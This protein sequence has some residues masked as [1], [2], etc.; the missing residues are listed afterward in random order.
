MNRKNQTTGTR[1][2]LME[3]ALGNRAPGLFIQN[4]DIFNT[5]T[6]TVDREM[7]LLVWKDRIAHVGP[8]AELGDAG[9]DAATIVVDAGGR[10]LIPGFIDSH[11]HLA[12]LVKP[13]EYVRHVLP[14]GCTT[15]ITETME[16]YPVAGVNGVKAYLEALKKQPMRF[17]TT[18]PAMAS[19]SSASLGLPEGDAEV[20]AALDGM[21]GVGEAYWQTVFQE[22]AHFLGLFEKTL[23]AGG[24][25]E[26]HSAGARGRKLSAYAALGVSSCH[27]PISADQVLE[28]LAM[29]FHVQI[30]EGSIRSDL[31][32]IAAIAGAGVDLS[33]ISLVSDGITPGDLLANGYMN[34]IVQK[35]VDNGFRPEDAIRMA[36]LN[37]ARHFRLDHEI[38]SLAPGRFADMVLIPD[39]ETIEPEMVIAKGAV[40]AENK[41]LRVTPVSHE[42]DAPCL[43]TVHLPADISEDDLAVASPGSGDTARVRTI[44]FIT[45]LVTREC[46]CDLP[47]SDG[48]VQADIGQDVIKAMAVDRACAPGLRTGRRFTGFVKGFGLKSGAL[49]TSAAWDGSE[50]I[51]LGKDDRDIALAVN[52]IRREK[53]GIVLINGGKVVRSFPLPVFGLLSQGSVADAAREISKVITAIQE[54]GCPFPDPLL[55]LSTLTGA[56][57]PFLR[58]CSEGLVAFKTGKKQALFPDH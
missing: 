9:T 28:R 56:A 38:G 3:V 45:D 27:E 12:W 11:T 42:F 20:L 22:S 29:G 51:A 36:T 30:R 54:L 19:I 5:W 21:V 53:G 6:G 2:E 15:I 32:E 10:V 58:I 18:L 17:Y 31:A 37:P 50:I 34:S 47:V 57:I 44:E 40:A 4:A 16:I 13:E 26:G 39:L 52:W 23:A 8:M 33:N 24:L 46:I 43:D 55:S 7:G 25:L 14:L 41:T 49:A 1:Q 35:A 48:R